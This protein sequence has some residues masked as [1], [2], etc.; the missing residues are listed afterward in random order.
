MEYCGGGSVADLMQAADAPLD[1]EVIAWLCCETLA[2]LAYL[3]SMG[4]VLLLFSILSSSLLLS[5]RATKIGMVA[6]TEGGWWKGKNVTAGN[7]L[8]ETGAP[9]YA[10]WSA[11]S[12][13]GP[14]SGSLS[15]R[16]W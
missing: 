16:V 15:S 12:E 5:L 6:A 3:H 8:D 7:T 2:G 11:V 14:Q 4:K 9:V 13:V 1:E 10:M